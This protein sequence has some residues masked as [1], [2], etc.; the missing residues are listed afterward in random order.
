MLKDCYAFFNKET[1]LFSV[2]SSAIEKVVRIKNS[3]IAAERITDKINGRSWCAEAPKWQHCP[4][5]DADEVP[6]IR[7]KTEENTEHPTMQPHMKATLEMIG[8]NGTVWYEYTVFSQLPFVYTQAFA[9]KRSGTVQ[10]KDTIL[11]VNSTGNENIR[12]EAAKQSM[13]CSADTLDCIPL[14]QCHLEVESFL[15]YDKTDINDSLLERQ[16]VPVYARG[17]LEREGNIFRISDIASGDSLLLIKHAPTPSSAL[18]RKGKD[19][20]VLGNSFAVLTGTGIDFE[21]MPEERIPYYASAVGAAKTADIMEAFHRYSCALSKGN[22]EEKLFIMSNTWGDRSR[23]MAVCEKFMLEEIEHGHRI[24]VDIV[25]I[26]DGW[27][28][29]VTVN[30]MRREGGVWEGY[31]AD[32]SDFWAVNSERFP[33]DLY[34]IVEKARSYG[35]EVGLWFSPDSSGEFSNFEK[36]IETLLSIYRKYGIR[37]FKLDGVKIRSKLCEKRFI[38][39]LETITALSG[40][41]VRFNL[42]VTAEDRF[43]Y[44]YYP[45]YGTL[46]VENRYTDWGNYYPH[47]TFR[48]LWSLSAVLPARRL[49]MELLNKNRNPEKYAGM[50]YAPENYEMDYLFASV[51]PA[52][53]LVW[54]ETSHLPEKDAK[55]LSEITAVHKT[56]AAELFEA[57]VM[58]I[59]EAPNGAHFSGYFCKNTDEKS[60]HIL[61][62]REET[63]QDTYTFSL[64]V[65]LEKAAIETLCQSTPVQVFQS[66]NTLTAK[67][68]AVRSFIWLR[69]E[70]R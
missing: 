40:G 63:K 3:C 17:M 39:M 27:Q 22:P 41:D 29:G 49:Q 42:D 31:Y 12:V 70:M 59:G 38:K 1:G 30:S 67:F 8:K 23:D 19:L 33:N 53:P 21:N 20:T 69:Y 14:G 35:M 32:S 37:Y 54:M 65:P 68:G 43:G 13:F 16:T 2:G 15:L 61:L 44:L 56:Y 7:I 10:T 36:D 9:E 26:D 60:G 25:Q 46:F 45:Q 5:L 24:G 34:P 50:P 6:E 4:V 48:N 47:N 66:G 55:T 58:P 28:S 52:N 51:L 64:P 62:F 57:R 18:N 11:S